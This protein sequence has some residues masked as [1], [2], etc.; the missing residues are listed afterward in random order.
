MF[1]WKQNPKSTSRAVQKTKKRCPVCSYLNLTLVGANCFA[2]S[3]LICSCFYSFWKIISYEDVRLGGL[4]NHFLLIVFTYPFTF[5]AARQEN[6][7]KHNE[8]RQKEVSKS[9]V[10]ENRLKLYPTT[11]ER[12]MQERREKKKMKC[13]MEFILY[14]IVMKTFDIS[15]SSKCI[16]FKL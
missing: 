12:R 8:S 16:F 6:R 15:N 10:F 9:T 4:R 3:I 1:W 7:K 11:Q 13:A 5:A 2:K 14:G